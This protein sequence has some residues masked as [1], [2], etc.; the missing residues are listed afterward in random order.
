MADGELD[1]PAIDHRQHVGLLLVRLVG[2][3]QVDPGEP[4][5]EDRRAIVGGLDRQFALEHP[6]PLRLGGGGSTP[7]LTR[8]SVT[9][10]WS[11]R[12]RISPR[13]LASGNASSATSGPTGPAWSG[14]SWG[15]PQ[16]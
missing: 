16:G 10:Q 2:A 11:L 14:T 13:T 4:L 5:V 7:S 9:L 8:K 6:G 12:R 1:V 3:I 15:V